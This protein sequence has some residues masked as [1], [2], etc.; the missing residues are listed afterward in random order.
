MRKKI[1]VEKSTQY[2]I[3]CYLRHGKGGREQE[4]EGRRERRK[5]ER[6]RK[7]GIKGEGKR[8][9]KRRTQRGRKRERKEGKKERKKEALWLF[10]SSN[11]VH[12]APNRKF[13]AQVR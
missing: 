5:G 3:S 9:K 13:T 12:A 2:F 4:K 10:A 7:G 8:R 11:S 6:R 1:H